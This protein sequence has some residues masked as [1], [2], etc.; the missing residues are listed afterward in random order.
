MTTATPGLAQR[1]V[2][3][4]HAHRAA[5]PDGFHR[6]HDNPEEWNRW[7][8]RARVAR[9]V[10]TA[11]Q[12]PTDA[13]LVTDDPH[14]TY[15]TRTGDVPG[16]LITTTDPATGHTWRFIPDHTTP[17]QAWLLLDTCPRCS[18][19]V[20]VTRIA[21]LADLG[22]HLDPDTRSA[23]DI[24]DAADHQPDCTGT[25]STEPS[26]E[27]APPCTRDPDPEPA[28]HHRRTPADPHDTPTRHPGRTATTA[29]TPADIEISP[30][31][32][33][34]NGCQV[35][36]IVVDPAGTRTLYGT[37]TRKGA[38]VGSYYRADRVRRS[39]WRIVT[40][41]GLPLTLDRHPVDLPSE[42]AAVHVLTT[43]LTARD[44]YEAE[45]RL[46]E[47]LRLPR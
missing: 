4:A 28:D 17:G 26:S 24:G 20:P 16:D 47:A 25:G 13:V 7:V 2:H 11:L 44:S 40:A 41:L 1:A 21:T 14:R 3:A 32:F 43:V 5:D 36:A 46:R 45:Q 8:R 19:E 23:R 12:V 10:A 22:D 9:T 18:A 39:S 15:P 37:V 31:R 29:H 34:E 33:T 6:R 42:G 35:T 27:G 30:R 38:F